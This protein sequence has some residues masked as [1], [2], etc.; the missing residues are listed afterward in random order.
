[1]VVVTIS[2]TTGE[3]GFGGAAAGPVFQSVMATAMR[4]LNVPRDVPEEVEE[5]MAK[6]AQNTDEEEVDETALASLNPPTEE[7]LREAAADSNTDVCC[8]EAACNSNMDLCGSATAVGDRNPRESVA[9]TDPNAQKA[10][11]LVGKTI[12]D[13]VHEAATR[14]LNV[15]LFGS[16]LSRT[17]SPPPGSALAPGQP[18]QVRFAH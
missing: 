10:P 13:V 3:A 17:Q 15:E 6:E 8:P 14:G 16:G 1:V 9:Q 5:L 12:K 11:D 18:I 7:E 4:R 2:G